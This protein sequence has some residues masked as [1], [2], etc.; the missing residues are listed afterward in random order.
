MSSAW[1]Y[2]DPHQVKEHGADK[3]SWYVGWYEPDGHRRGKSCGPGFMG[4][5]NAERLKRK[6]EAELLTGT[7]ES[8]KRKAWADF[9][10][11]YE[12]MILVNKSS[13]TRRA[14]KSS[15]DHF[16]RIVRPRSVDSIRTQHI[17]QFIATRSTEPGLRRGDCVSLAT[18]N[19]DLRIVKAA[20][21]VAREYKYLRECP[22]FRMLNEPQKLPSYVSGVDFAAIYRHC[23]TA[24]MPGDLPNT[25]SSDWW[26]A[27]LVF[28]YMTGWR[29]GVILALRRE[30]VDF[31][32]G[33]AVSLAADNK[34]K[35][36]EQIKLHPIVIEHLGRIKHFGPLIFPWNHNRRTLYT[37]F[38]RIQEAAGIK[39]LCDDKHVHTRYCY[40]YGF[41]DLRRAFATMN[42]DKLTADALQSL[43]RH[44]SYQT[45]Q[46]Y[47]N[48]SRQIDAS[49]AVL[50]VP[51]VLRQVAT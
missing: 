27:L 9:R 6:L 32:L 5:K 23:D 39:L 28:G 13:S 24:K 31:E 30:R 45:T 25:R 12:K 11:E 10:T 14:A 40:V 34:G 4:K 44:K 42:A 41:H 20:L 48:M 7:Y 37:E 8:Q 18:V 22:K 36:D 47:I 21:N 15:L 19:H 3:S 2:Q 26:R 51:E 29:I 49:V 1:I 50:H 17:D 16:E 33:T 46:R 35:R 43:M 38:A